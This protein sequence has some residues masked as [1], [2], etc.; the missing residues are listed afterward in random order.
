MKNK[1]KRALEKIGLKPYIKK[2]ISNGPSV[3]LEK[4][5]KLAGVQAESAGFHHVIVH[6]LSEYEQYMQQHASKLNRHLEYEQKLLSHFKKTFTI[7]APSFLTGKREQYT[8]QCKQTEAG[9]ES[10]LRETCVCGTTGLNNRIRATLYAFLSTHQKDTLDHKRIYLTE[11]VT[12]LYAYLKSNFAHVEGSE[13]LGEQI[14]S[15]TIIN[16]VRHEDVTRMSYANESFDFGFSLE[17]LEHVPE[18]QKAFGELARITKKGGAFYITVPFLEKS[19]HTLIRARLKT[20]GTIEHLL[21]PEYHGDPVNAQGGILCFQH[22]SWDMRDDLIKA[23]FTQVR[24]HFIW[25]FDEVLLGY[26][27]LVIEAIK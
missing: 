2:I 7:E 6:S 12:S 9:T 19:Q 22:F 10:N 17:V 4:A 8:I 21:P 1:I 13:Y 25:S 3:S 5:K 11:A 15:G 27:T 16:G 14:K 24:F 20:D 23:G 18:Y 26:H